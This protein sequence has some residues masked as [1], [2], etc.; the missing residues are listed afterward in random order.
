MIKKLERLFSCHGYGL[1]NLVFEAFLSFTTFRNVP[2]ADQPEAISGV[3]Y[4]LSG[5]D[6][7]NGQ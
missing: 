1:E 4:L 6:Q 5:S 3:P 2:K 7:T